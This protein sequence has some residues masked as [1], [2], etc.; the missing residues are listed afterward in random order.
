MKIVK[1]LKISDDLIVFND[2]ILNQYS[3]NMS[4]D[5]DSKQIKRTLMQV[6]VNFLL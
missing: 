3:R 6:F 5:V 2:P 1:S 4:G